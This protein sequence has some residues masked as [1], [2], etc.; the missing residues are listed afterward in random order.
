MLERKHPSQVSWNV[1]D[2]DATRHTIGTFRKLKSRRNGSG[3]HFK[4]SFVAG[5][6]KNT[7]PLGW[8]C[9]ASWRFDDR[10]LA[11]DL[12]GGNM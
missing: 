9:S 4:V 3:D 5:K 1:P 12:S 10:W 7:P 6:E 11:Q 2:G 8:L